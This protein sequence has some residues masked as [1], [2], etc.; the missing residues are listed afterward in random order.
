MAAAYDLVLLFADY[1]GNGL[2]GR[3]VVRQPLGAGGGS[4]GYPA[5]L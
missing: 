3:R 4:D 5:T 2:L 1:A